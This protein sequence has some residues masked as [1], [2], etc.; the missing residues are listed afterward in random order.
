MPSD[1]A[2]ATRTSASERMRATRERRRRGAVLVE[3]EVDAG[4][5][6]RLIAVGML[7]ADQRTDREAVGAA[8]LGLTRARSSTPSAVAFAEMLAEALRQKRN[9][10]Y[11]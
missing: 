9:G 4:M 11:G 7:S 8:L 10:G 3:V 5:L 2:A 1:A 6:D